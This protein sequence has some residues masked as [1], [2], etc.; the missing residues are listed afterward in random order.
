MA[1]WAD[2]GSEGEETGLNFAKEHMNLTQHIPKWGKCN[3][4][5]CKLFQA[6]GRKKEITTP[7]SD[8]SRG[9]PVV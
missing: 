5:S 8:D 3:D 4:L 1:E 7:R 6:S 9:V 2:R